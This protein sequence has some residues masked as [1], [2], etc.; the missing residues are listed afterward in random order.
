MQQCRISYINSI[1]S[2]PIVA[3]WSLLIVLAD[4]T[5]TR[6]TSSHWQFVVLKSLWIIQTCSQ[7]WATWFS[8]STT[9]NMDANTCKKK[10]NSSNLFVPPSTI[11]LYN[12]IY[13]CIYI[14][15][16]YS[17]WMVIPWILFRYKKSILK[18]SRGDDFRYRFEA[19]LPPESLGHVVWMTE[20][21]HF[22][23]VC[24]KKHM[25]S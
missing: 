21:A 18:D 14:Y 23:C 7:I 20:F 13:V 16:R 25:S 10:M 3:M 9:Q 15:S 5:V 24:W 4:M 2:K 22:L 19:G 11:C 1:I 6:P 8:G 17:S 12:W